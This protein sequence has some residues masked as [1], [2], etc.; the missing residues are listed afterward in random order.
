MEEELI[1][2]GLLIAGVVI[3]KLYVACKE[4]INRNLQIRRVQKKEKYWLN[5]SE[6]AHRSDPSY[7]PDW[8]QRKL[9]VQKRDNYTCKFCNFSIFTESEIKE[10]K[11]TR[12]HTGGTGLHIHHIIPL[13][14]GGSNR[15]SNLISLCETCHEDQHPHMIKKKITLYEEKYKLDKDQNTKIMWQN[16][17]KEAKLRYRKAK[18]NEKNRDMNS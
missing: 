4:A 8:A 14:K 3:Y 6:L 5:S 9:N 12:G 13:S 2:F 10:A 16:K 7:P 11:L 17:L 18:I 15:L 1:T